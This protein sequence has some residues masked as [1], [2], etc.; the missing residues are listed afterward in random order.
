MKEN[1]RMPRIPDEKILSILESEGLITSTQ[2]KACITYQQEYTRNTGQK[3]PLATVMEKLKIMSADKISSIVRAIESANIPDTLPSIGKD[4]EDEEAPP[5]PRPRISP[6]SLKFKEEKEEKEEEEEEEEEQRP[7]KAMKR[8]LVEVEREEEEEE[9][10]EEES[11]ASSDEEFEDEKS[12]DEEEREDEDEEEREEME[13]KSIVVAYLLLLL[14]GMVGAHRFYLRHYRSAVLYALTFGFLG[15]GVLLDFFL[16][17]WMMRRYR[18]LAAEGKIPS[19]WEELARYLKSSDMQR[20]PKWAQRE[21]ALQKIGNFA[22]TS[23]QILCMFAFPVLLGGIA[24]AAWNPIV[25]LLSF[26]W[27]TV[28]LLGRP[29]TKAIA[30]QDGWQHVPFLSFFNRNI[31]QG[32]GFYFHH[33]PLSVLGYILYPLWMPFSILANPKRRL[34]SFLFLW[35]V[36]SGMVFT[37]D[38]LFYL[39]YAF[40][41]VYRP[42]VLHLLLIEGIVYLGSFLLAMC[43]SVPVFTSLISFKLRQKNTATKIFGGWGVFV[44]AAFCLFLLFGGTWRFWESHQHAYRRVITRLKVEPER[45]SIKNSVKAFVSLVPENWAQLPD[46]ELQKYN[47]V[48]PNLISKDSGLYTLSTVISPS[49]AKA[50]IVKAGHYPLM[51]MDQY[52]QAYT[53]WNQL[54]QAY[55][56]VVL[57]TCA[58][59]SCPWMNSFLFPSL[60]KE[61]LL[62]DFTE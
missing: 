11:D 53:S 46:E 7:P 3:I 13:Q 23:L 39:L 29:L 31:D 27:F 40:D 37:S 16:I 62:E 28:F 54:P 4:E 44:S 24:L 47:P 61:R 21:T 58:P 17:P 19:E 6:A 34:E 8:P 59:P 42:P 45:M 32:L 60:P 2:Q 20:S 26:A 50:L 1:F 14:F 18:K 5:K 36:I 52:R 25:P 10:E 57:E 48:L 33:A 56:K 38:I 41:F 49:G 12:E 35:I 15:V 22:N 55:Q 30:S 51:L 9:E 43:F